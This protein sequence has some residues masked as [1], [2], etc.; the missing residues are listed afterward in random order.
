MHF[1]IDER[2][3][4]HFQVSMLCNNI[5]LIAKTVWYVWNVSYQDVRAIINNRNISELFMLLLRQ[6]EG[7]D[8]KENIATKVDSC[9]VSSFPRGKQYFQ[10]SKCTNLMICA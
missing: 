8:L 9:E 6:A 5:K 2:I 7:S 4:I 1:Y 3:F 10:M